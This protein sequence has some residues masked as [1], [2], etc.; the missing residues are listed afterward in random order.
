LTTKR[1]FHKSI[2][3]REP[4]TP[5]QRT[6]LGV[7]KNKIAFANT[8]PVVLSLQDARVH[9]AVPKQQPRHTHHHT[10]T[11]QK[12]G[13]FRVW[14]RPCAGGQN[15]RNPAPPASGW[16]TC[17]QVAGA[18]VVSGPNSVPWARNHRPSPPRSNTPHKGGCV[19]GK[20]EPPGSGPR[21]VDIPP[22]STRLP[23]QVAAT[24][25]H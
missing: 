25:K 9:Y 18:P 14:P 23:T 10:P 1:S 5:P 20:R 13:S 7:P 17:K 15:T 22:M 6:V 24:G 8:T 16:A 4:P 12:K 3:S 2:R 19:L 21:F 11:P